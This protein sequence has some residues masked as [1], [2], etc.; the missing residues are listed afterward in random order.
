MTNRL[1]R[2]I[3]R[4]NFHPRSS[5]WS[6]RTLGVVQRNKIARKTSKYAFI[7]VIII[8]VA[9]ANI[10][11]KGALIDKPDNFGKKDKNKNY[12]KG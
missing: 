4:R 12:Q 3:G 2:A 8:P 11:I 7:I 10:C 6:I 5:S 9:P 1:T